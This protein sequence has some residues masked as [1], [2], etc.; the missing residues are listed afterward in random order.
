MSLFAIAFLLAAW[1]FLFVY[2]SEPLV[3]FNRTFSEK[4]VLA[5]MSVITVVVVF[6][7]TDVGS[8]LM[9]AV[10]FGFL[11]VCA[12]A[13]FRVPDDLF[14]DEQPSSGGFLSFLGEN[15]PKPATIPVSRV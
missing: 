12:H 15:V 7:L 14:L 11:I 6:L 8:L 1:A 2:R 9:S 13:A 5:L 4:E 10:M 3:L